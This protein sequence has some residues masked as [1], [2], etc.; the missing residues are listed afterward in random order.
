MARF[1]FHDKFFRFKYNFDS[2]CSSFVPDFDNLH[3]VFIVNGASNESTLICVSCKTLGNDL[4]LP[5]KIYG[6]SDHKFLEKRDLQE[7]LNEERNEFIIL[8][9]R[10]NGKFVSRNVVNLSKRKLLKCEISL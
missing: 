1:G 5:N 6:K 3:Y 2:F 7:N 8:N 10:L 4:N 9:G